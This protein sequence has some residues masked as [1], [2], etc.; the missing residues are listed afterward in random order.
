VSSTNT[1]A[2]MSGDPFAT[3]SFTE[4][5]LECMIL[6]TSCCTVLVRIVFVLCC[7]LINAH[8]AF[9][10]HCWIIIFYVF[11]YKC[12]SFHINYDNDGI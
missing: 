3:I 6:A 9:L 5:M 11:V 10:V 1:D 8:P 2:V 12:D 4:L 7:V